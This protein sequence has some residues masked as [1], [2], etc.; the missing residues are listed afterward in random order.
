MKRILI[1][2][3]FIIFL[4]YFSMITGKIIASFEN[5]NDNRTTDINLFTNGYEDN[6]LLEELNPF[7]MFPDSYYG[8]Y[9]PETNSE[10]ITVAEN[11]P[12]G[13]RKKRRTS[14]Y[15]GNGFNIEEESG[16][17][18]VYYSGAEINSTQ[19]K[20]KR[21]GGKQES[22]DLI[23][24]NYLSYL[25]SGNSLIVDNQGVVSGSNPV[26]AFGVSRVD[27]NSDEFNVLDGPLPPD[28]EPIPFEGGGIIALFGGAVMAWFGFRKKISQ[29]I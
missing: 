12:S 14:V 9:V 22:A 7:S 8:G 28:P 6:S 13:N 4:V 16:N 11:Q 17:S 23:G 5:F 20:N 10:E 19:G 26:G 29:L 25:N 21:N 1:Y 15:S 27:E 18:A 24:S 3:G 2:T